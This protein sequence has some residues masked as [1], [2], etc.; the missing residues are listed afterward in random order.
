MPRIIISAG[1]EHIGSITSDP[2]GVINPAGLRGGTGANGEV[3]WTTACADALTAMLAGAGVD[4]V[5][6]D[7]IYHADVY[8]PDADLVVVLHYDGGA[9]TGRAQYCMAATVH[10]GPST[11]EADSRA[12]AFVADW[13]TVYCAQTG[14]AGDGPITTNMTQEY[15]G[16]Y[17]SAN[18]PMV[19]LEHCLG[20]DAGGIRADRPTPEQGAAA[21]FAALAKHF[22]LGNTPP[23]QPTDARLF[24]ETGKSISGMFKGFYEQWDD[25]AKSLQEY[26]YPVTDVVPETPYRCQYF[27]R[28]VM[29]DHGGYIQLR[30]LGAAAAKAAGHTGPG[31]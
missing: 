28:V 18:T 21:D 19:L 9:G 24:P 16:W 14:I 22:N 17:R 12:D 2:N 30:R 29:E 26:G 5:R 31:I 13:Y 20:A 7:A 4:A 1:H 25:D 27:E 15:E 8:G 3:Q 6:T 23:P 10:S 11:V